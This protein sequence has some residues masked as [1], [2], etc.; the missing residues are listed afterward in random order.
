M[1]SRETSPVSS[2]ASSC[3]VDGTDEVDLPP[4]VPVSD[5]GLDSIVVVEAIGEVEAKYN[6]H[7]QT[8]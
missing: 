5:L 7:V 4:D 3:G 8:S 1:R 2:C 6:I